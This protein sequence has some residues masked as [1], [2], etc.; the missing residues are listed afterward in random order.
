LILLQN[1]AL[2]RPSREV[3]EWILGS[4]Q[5]LR[6]CSARGWRSCS[7]FAQSPPS[8]RTGIG[9]HARQGRGVLHVDFPWSI[10]SRLLTPYIRFW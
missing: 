2:L 1:S 10:E 3:T 6:S 7:A 4:A 8:Q 5:E 9:G